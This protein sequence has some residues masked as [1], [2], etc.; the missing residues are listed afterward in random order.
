MEL[1]SLKLDSEYQ[2]Y[3]LM[4]FYSS[5]TYIR[6]IIKEKYEIALIAKKVYVYQLPNYRRENGRLFS[7][8]GDG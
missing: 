8:D 1:R 7:T 2:I 3:D 6:L 5:Y 4:W